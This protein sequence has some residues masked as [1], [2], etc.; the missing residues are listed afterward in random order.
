[1]TP[2]RLHAEYEKDDGFRT[3]P[4][5]G[6]IGGAAPSGMVVFDLYAERFRGPDFVQLSVSDSGVS[7]TDRG[8]ERTDDG[9]LRV[10][11]E[12]LV[13]CIARPEVAIAIGQWLI[14]QGRRIAETPEVRQ[15]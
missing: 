8:G 7:E 6:V 12:R 1:M 3:I 5:S 15:S 2:I 13:C 11:R 10:I 9:A 14:E 4:V